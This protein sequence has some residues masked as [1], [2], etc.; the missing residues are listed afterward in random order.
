MKGAKNL[1]AGWALIGTYN[2]PRRFLEDVREAGGGPYG[3]RVV[4]KSRIQSSPVPPADKSMWM[5]GLK[6]ARFF[7]ESGWEL[8]LVWTPWPSP[9]A[10]GTS[11][12]A[13]RP[14]AVLRPYG[15]QINRLLKEKT[16]GR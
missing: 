3:S 6:T 16:G 11:G 12:S 8:S 9:P 1:D 4:M 2:D 13:R 15:Q 14:E 7:P 5:A 10:S